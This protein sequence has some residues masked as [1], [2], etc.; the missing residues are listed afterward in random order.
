[1]DRERLQREKQSY[2]SGSIKRKKLLSVLRFCYF[3]QD[4][5][6][7]QKVKEQLENNGPSKCLELGSRTWY[8]WMHLNNYFPDSLHCIN[9][10]DRELMGGVKLNAE[11]PYEIDF[12]IMDAHNLE[13]ESNSFDLVF[14]RGIL[15]HLELKSAL[16]EV[17]RV[18]K[19]DGII[20]FHEPLDINPLYKL[21]R[22]LTPKQRTKDEKA[23]GLKELQ[24]VKSHFSVEIY[25]YNI[26]SIPLG[27]LA[28]IIFKN[29]KN[30]ISRFAAKIDSL[31]CKT[32]FLQLLSSKCLIVSKSSN[33][34]M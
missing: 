23:F 33:T 3:Y 4:A 2:D 13:F 10:S 14:G 20:I 34:N 31:L 25:Y 28:Y 8:G 21:Y 27:C 17:K 26:V 11:L 19:N 1:M 12:S 18:L 29:H 9:L 32:P 5:S 22:L 6:M 24:A 16:H 15:H 7:R 30:F